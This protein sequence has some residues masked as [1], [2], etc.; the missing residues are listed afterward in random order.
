MD[1]ATRITSSGDQK[2]EIKIH[3]IYVTI[4]SGLF[5]FAGLFC[6]LN[7]KEGEDKKS[8]NQG[9]PIK[10]ARIGNFVVADEDEAAGQVFWVKNQNSMKLYLII[11]PPHDPV[12]G[13]VIFLFQVDSI[14]V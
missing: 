12:P 2:S 3:K 5:F 7:L 8:E 13:R 4:H 9:N 1:S 14:Y 6:P 10:H 11:E